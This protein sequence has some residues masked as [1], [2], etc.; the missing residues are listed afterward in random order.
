MET[1]EASLLCWLEN[2]FVKCEFSLGI[3]L[4]I[5]WVSFVYSNGLECGVLVLIFP[6]T[7]DMNT[8]PL[9]SSNP[10]LPC[11]FPLLFSDLKLNFFKRSLH[12]FYVWI[13]TFLEE[14]SISRTT[15][16]SRECIL[17]KTPRKTL[18][19]TSPDTDLLNTV[20]RWIASAISDS[21]KDFNT[22]G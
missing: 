1:Q 19:L 12:F 10:G 7:D 14:Y 9:S 18:E 11:F 15:R 20:E 17:V 2:S 5:K 3:F 8:Y 13:N 16:E 21:D 4:L 6:E 22:L